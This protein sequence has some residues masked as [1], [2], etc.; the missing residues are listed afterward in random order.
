[1][2]IKYVKKKGGYNKYARGIVIGIVLIV[3]MGATIAI[4]IA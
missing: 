4:L 2:R 3:V 1:M